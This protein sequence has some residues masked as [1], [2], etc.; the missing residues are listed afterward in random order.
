MATIRIMC[1][2]NAPCVFSLIAVVTLYIME[3]QYWKDLLANMT[4]PDAIPNPAL[5]PN[6]T[7][8]RRLIPPRASR[9]P[10]D[11]NAA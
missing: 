9:V 7:Q 5:L 6:G 3:W 11:D 1:Y 4:S 2:L 8:L 10:R